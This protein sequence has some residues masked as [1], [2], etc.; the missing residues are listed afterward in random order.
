[1]DANLVEFFRHF[2]RVRKTGRVEELTGVSI[3]SSGIEFHMFNAAFFS[4]PVTGGKK[5]LDRRVD[6][7]AAVLGGH[8]GRWA[9][10]AS[11]TALSTAV[12]GRAAATFR[13]YGLYEA[14][15]HPG[16]ICEEFNPPRRPLPVL[17]IR[18]VVDA[19]GR[20][21]FARL[22]SLA[23]HIPFEWCLDLYEIEALWDTRFAGYIGYGE[24]QALCCAATLVAAGVVGVY[25]VATLP[26]HEHKGY[27][28]AITRHAVAEARRESG[29]KQT[30]LQATKAGLPLYQ[31]LG[32]K[33]VTHFLIYSP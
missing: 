16:L 11:A 23:F 12:E 14:F 13:R 22:N 4:S 18:R 2:A 9:F 30:I 7:A 29:L 20:I 25:S 3:A 17:E 1:V 19:A 33:L 27:G 21:E 26:G 8:G 5:D 24:G 32:Y 6:L 15:R 28:E 31:R 10:W